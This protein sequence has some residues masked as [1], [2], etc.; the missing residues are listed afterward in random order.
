MTHHESLPAA[1]QRRLTKKYPATLAVFDA[2]YAE[3]LARCELERFL[4][5]GCRLIRN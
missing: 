1:H 2:N 5:L 3:V 4:L